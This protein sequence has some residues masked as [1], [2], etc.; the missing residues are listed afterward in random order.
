MK[1]ILKNITVFTLV[2]IVLVVHLPN[3]VFNTTALAKEETKASSIGGVEIEG[4]NDQ[5]MEEALQAAVSSWLSKPLAVTGGGVTTKIEPSQF[6]FDVTSS[7]NEYK[8]LTKKP[9]YAFWKSKRTVHIPLQVNLNEEIKVQLQGVGVWDV[10][11]TFDSVMEKASYLKGH[12]VKATVLD[13]NLLESERIG[14]SIEEIP[15]TTLG[16]SEV[17]EVLNDKIIPP[18]EHFSLLTVLA[19]NTELANV[20]GLDFVASMLYNTVLQTDF[21]I[22]ERHAQ[23]GIPPYLQAGT[24]ASINL[25]LEKDLQFINLSALPAKL[26]MSIDGNSLKV[27]LFSQVKEKDITVRVEKDRIVDPRIIYRYSNELAAGK[28][29]TIQ[30]G[31]KGL[32]I[33]VYRSI[34]EQ[35]ISSEVLMSRDYYAPINRIVERSSRQL[36]TNNNNNN[37]QTNTP[38]NTTDDLDLKLDLDGNGLADTPSKPGGTPTKPGDSSSTSGNQQASDDPDLVYGYYDKGGNFVQTS[39]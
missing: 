24:E 18:D 13:T 36:T 9:W 15:T 33:E 11:K 34:L 28:E 32:R 7:I 14:L 25:V 1:R 19:E 21:E 6:Q 39:P 27:E 37:G 10:E 30:E 17:A 23:S 38:S 26:K 5:K 35:G 2:S 20:E 4:L 22:L 16:V 8:R 12:E 29:K 3:M 31:T